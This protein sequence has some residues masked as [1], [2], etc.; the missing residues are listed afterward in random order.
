MMDCG[1]NSL[2]GL[3]ISGSDM[4]AEVSMRRWLKIDDH[5]Y[6]YLR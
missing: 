2:V 6:N 5:M 3:V 1:V 4:T